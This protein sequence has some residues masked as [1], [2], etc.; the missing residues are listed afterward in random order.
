MMLKGEELMIKDNIDF[1]KNKVEKACLRAGRNAEDVLLL[2]VTKTHQTSIVNEAL[3]NGITAFGENKVQEIEL[4]MPE[5][6]R[7]GKAF[8]FIGHL[9]SNKINKLLRLKPDLIHSIDKYSTAEKIDIALQKMESI[10]DV[11]IEV[12]TSGEKSKNGVNPG[13]LNKLVEQIANL[14]HI[15]I[16]GLMTIGSLTENEEEV[17]RCFRELRSLFLAIKEQNINNIEMKYLSMGMSGDFEIA[18]EEGSN[19]VRVGSLIF[20]QRI[21]T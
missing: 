11:L 18:I 8:H 2:A 20:G 1:V 7:A 9:Q 10:Q 4:K 17:R 6:E 16:K 3:A 14:K 13:K 15:R 5:I 21:Y 19:I 12:N